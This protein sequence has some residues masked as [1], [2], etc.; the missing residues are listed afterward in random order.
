MDGQLV[1]VASSPLHLPTSHCSG[2]SLFPLRTLFSVHRSPTA[3]QH[4]QP[5]RLTTLDSQDLHRNSHT[6]R[7]RI[8]AAAATEDAT[9]PLLPVPKDD[10]SLTDSTVEAT[11]DP[12]RSR[13]YVSIPDTIG[14]N[15]S[16]RRLFGIVPACPFSPQG[17]L[18][19]PVIDSNTSF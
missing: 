1:L 12:D 17:V 15:K 19:L 5:H 18:S 7:R 4:P 8:A 13:P 16:K 9:V 2:P 3:L 6:S 10:P 14:G 11:P